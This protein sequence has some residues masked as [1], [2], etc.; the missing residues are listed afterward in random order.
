[1]GIGT[2]RGRP[3]YSETVEAVRANLLT[4]TYYTISPSSGAAAIVHRFD[5]A[6]G[7]KTIQTNAD[8]YSDNNLDNLPT[9]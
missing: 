9:Y 4:Q 2:T 6:C 8:P 7:V 3:D 1:V 5:C